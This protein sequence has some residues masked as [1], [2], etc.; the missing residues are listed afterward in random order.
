MTINNFKS[1]RLKNNYMTVYNTVTVSSY[2]LL[3][4]DCFSDINQVN[5]SRSEQTENAEIFIDDDYR[6]KFAFLI[7]EV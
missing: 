3:K 7:P 5:K 6:Q 2:Y 1:L 4:K